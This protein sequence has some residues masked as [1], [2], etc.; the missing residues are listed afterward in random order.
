MHVRMNMLA[1]DPARLD[2]ATRYIERTVRPHVEALHGNR[3]LAC[4]I[5]ADLGVC[6]VASYWDTLDAMTASEQEVQVSRKEATELVE[7]TVT[8][9]HYEVPA[10]VR[11]SR[12]QQGAGVRLSRFDCA[13]ASIDAVI[14]EFRNTGVPAL[15]D[16]PGLCS[17]HMMTDRATGRCIVITAWQD[18]DAL[19]ASRSA[20]A[21]L[22]ADVAAKTHLQVRSVEEYQLV[23]SS[24]RDGD[25]RS[26]IER[27][28]EL[29]NARDREGWMAGLDLH[30]L[31]MQAP[32]GLR[33][34]GQEAAE[35]IWNTYNEAFPDN[36]LEIIAIHADDRGG[37]HEGRATGTH[38]GTLRG[39]AGEIAAT[40]RT[41]DMRFTGVYEF[42]EGK[43]TSFHLYFDQAELLSQLGLAAGGTTSGALPADRPAGPGAQQ[44]SVPGPA[45][46]PAHGGEQ[47]VP[48][49]GRQ[50]IYGRGQPAAA[51]RQQ[52]AQWHVK[53]ASLPPSR[54]PK[55]P[56]AS[57][58]HRQPPAHAECPSLHRQCPTSASSR[59]PY[60]TA[61]TCA[62][63]PGQ[64]NYT[65]L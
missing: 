62:A 22:R 64:S 9:E 5:N 32:G 36:R 14:E 28:I 37:V 30:R 1:G 15:M 57:G 63:S 10:F 35:T 59:G 17:A 65:A 54:A 18:R 38:T 25:T 33:L 50:R 47:A 60:R 34:T 16:M 53:P 8:I 6:V 31:E 13:P 43:I 2:E 56:D 19:A 12:P 41:A 42:E 46:R 7:G 27:D 44:A 55:N 52:A 23:F 20:T 45:V 21:R 24:V 49:A 40:G 26:L 51:Q 39:P 4:L 61:A 3:G 11:R 48:I 29:W 58:D